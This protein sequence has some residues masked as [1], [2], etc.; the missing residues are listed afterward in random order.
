MALTSSSGQTPD[1]AR[2]SGFPGTS[3]LGWELLFF[4][5]DKLN[6]S[7]VKA[8]PSVLGKVKQLAILSNEATYVAARTL[9][10]QDTAS[11]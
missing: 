8:L 4:Q 9:Q 2:V 7:R 6:G 1:E 3:Q 5:D 11:H 10:P